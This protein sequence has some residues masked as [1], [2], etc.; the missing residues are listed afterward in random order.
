MQ[1]P[2]FI[3]NFQNGINQSANL[4]I[5]T[6]VGFDAYTKP[7]AVILGKKIFSTFSFGS[8]GEYPTYVDF[9]GNN[10]GFFNTRMW[11]QTAIGTVYYSDNYSSASP[12]FTQVVM[13]SP[14]VGEGQG[15]IVYEN[16]VFVF[17][18][19]QI[20][21]SN[22]NA[23]A[24]SPTIIQWKT[25]LGGG[26]TSPIPFNHFPFLFPSNRGFYFGNANAV[27]FIGQVFPVGSATPTAFNP[28][29]TVNTDYLYNPTILTMPAN[30]IVN[31]LDFLPPSLLAI[32]ANNL[33][34]GQEADIFTWDTVSA[35]K[36]SAPIKIYSG[37]NVTGAQGIKHFVNRLNV[38]YTAVG[39]NHGF[40]ST[41]GG[42]ANIIADLSLYA[43]VREGLI[44]SN[45][46][47]YPI[48][49]Y[50]NSFPSAISVSGNKI[51]T[52]TG[53]SN[54]NAY[55]PS[56]TTGVFPTG[57]WSMYFNNDGSVIKQME[58][59]I[60]FVGGSI[61]SISSFSVSGDYSAITVI[62]PY[63]N[64]QTGVAYATRFGGS[65]TTGTIVSFDTVSYI[66][67]RTLTSLESELFEIG[68]A[69]NPQVPNSIEINL[70]KNL[71][72]GQ[73]VEISYRKFTDANWSVIQTFTGDGTRNYYSIQ[74]HSI[75]PTQYLQ[76]RVRANTGL[77]NPN[78]TPELRNI[79]IS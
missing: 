26:A 30:Y 41:N 58:Y 35:N 44:G 50:Y 48:P 18:E 72:A 47:E 34:S 55:F 43:N 45:G 33:Q 5:G 53:T 1:K 57:V 25:G 28:A 16:Y 29:G 59:S 66:Q 8:N 4:G 74:Q 49:V 32:G 14:P 61:G 77:E 62:K 56:S 24:T 76:L 75:G 23:S 70:I 69:L 38:L 67:D 68:T 22:S 63:P 64:G 36:F 15:L 73:Q 27:G 51:L 40:Y 3:N 21:Y 60:P 65:V 12:T 54:V 39:G 13:T 46:K 11:V 20:W 79:K 31:T 52:G 19:T 7:G 10:A 78:D 2:V 17:F 6:I 42:T 37:T 71:L 9:S